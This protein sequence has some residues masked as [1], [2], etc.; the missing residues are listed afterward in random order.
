[1]TISDTCGEMVIFD[2]PLGEATVSRDLLEKR[3]A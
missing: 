1:V 2:T 3:R